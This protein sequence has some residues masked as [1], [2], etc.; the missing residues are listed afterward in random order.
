M[1]GLMQKMFGDKFWKNV[2]IEATHWHYYNKSIEIRQS[3][4][5]P[6]LEDWWTKQFNQ[7][8]KREYG[9]SFDL[10]S[11]FI[12]TYYNKSNKQELIKFQENTVKLYNF[13]STHNPFQC[14]DIN[15]ALT[16]I[17]E[18]QEKSQELEETIVALKVDKNKATEENFQLEQQLK[19]QNQE[20]SNSGYAASLQYKYCSSN[21]CYSPIEFALY[22]FG[23]C[24]AGGHSIC[25]C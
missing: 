12:D 6:I 2:I 22:G 23:I 11:V 9:L 15:I 16:E 18:L 5:P 25:L 1:I 4:N 14:K 19:K 7:L 13:A 20:T 3:S 24:I 17:G 8:F 10:P 21:K